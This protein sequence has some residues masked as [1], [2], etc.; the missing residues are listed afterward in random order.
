M[1]KVDGRRSVELGDTVR[2]GLLQVAEGNQSCDKEEEDVAPAVKEGTTS[3]GSADQ[4]GLEVIEPSD[5]LRV[6]GG[7]AKVLSRGSQRQEGGASRENR[8]QKGGL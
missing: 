8:R 2:S 7:K 6:A 4:A 1:L 3:V 5:I